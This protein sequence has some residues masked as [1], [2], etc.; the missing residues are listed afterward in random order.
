MYLI[1]RSYA[2]PDTDPGSAGNTGS[3]LG[4]TVSR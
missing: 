1:L 3:A 4:F 2:D